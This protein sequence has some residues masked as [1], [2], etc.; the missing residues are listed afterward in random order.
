MCDEIRGQAKFNLKICYP[1]D[2][3]D[4]GASRSVKFDL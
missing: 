1:T 3:D 2:V 4:C